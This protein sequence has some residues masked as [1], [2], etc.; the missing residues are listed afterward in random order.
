MLG[1]RAIEV[2]KRLQEWGQA[3]KP[4]PALLTPEM[5]ANAKALLLP[6]FKPA[7]IE[8]VPQLATIEAMIGDPEA[9]AA[10]VAEVIREGLTKLRSEPEV[11]PTKPA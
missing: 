1:D 8:A 3:D 6:I 4:Q 9:L 11:A 2:I 5:K 7:L 10:L